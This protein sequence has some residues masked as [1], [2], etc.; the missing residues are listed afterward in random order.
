MFASLCVR[1]PGAWADVGTD[2]AAAFIRQIGNEIADIV[3]STGSTGERSQRLQILVDRVADVD[4][5][6][7][8][9]LGRFW[10]QASPA[11]QREYVV[12]FHSILMKVVLARITTESQDPHHVR[13][14]IRRPEVRQETVYVPTIVE[15]SGNPPVQVTWVVHADALHPRL[16]DVIAEGT[17]LRLTVRSDYNAFLTRHDNNIDLLLQALRDQVCDHC[18]STT[19]SAAR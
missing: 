16:L 10:R 7:R 19:S 12:L 11:Q 8:F 9:C 18:A 13:V 6:A 15:R 4:D 3:G 14:T 2:W 5:A 1:S 17:S